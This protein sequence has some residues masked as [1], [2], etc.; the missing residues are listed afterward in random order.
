MKKIILLTLF[1]SPLA[2]CGQQMFWD[3]DEG[4]QQRAASRSYDG[5][6]DSSQATAVQQDSSDVRQA[7]IIPPSMREDVRLPEEDAIAKRAVDGRQTS[8]LISQ[9]AEQHVKE[10]GASLTS[11]TRIY[12]QDAAKAFSATIDA[13]TSLNM[14]IGSVDSPSGTITTDWIRQDAGSS[15]LLTNTASNILG[16]DSIA[17]TRHRFVVRIMRT[18]SGK[19]QVQV[20]NMHQVFKNR[21]WVNQPLQRRY[22][23]EL[24]DAIS[25]QLAK[26]SKPVTAQ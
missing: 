18:E 7:L 23:L 6:A 12:E 8:T 2:S 14:P 3:V 1:I 4:A 22:D 19:A 5:K 15:N 11:N 13:M 26:T 17:A 24:F 21:H 10:A 25:E 20:R 16:G 9:Q